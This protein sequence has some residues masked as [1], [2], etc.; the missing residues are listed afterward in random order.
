M[1]PLVEHGPHEVVVVMSHEGV[2][3][4]GGCPVCMADPYAASQ[5]LRELLLDAARFVAENPHG[6]DRA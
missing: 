1:N 5:R 3:Q 6:G 2:V 4:V